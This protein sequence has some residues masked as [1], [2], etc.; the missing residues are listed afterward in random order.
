[1][2]VLE[3]S[4]R[5]DSALTYTKA[6]ILDAAPNRPG[7]L[8]VVVLVTDGKSDE[9]TLYISYL[10]EISWNLF[11]PQSLYRTTFER[12]NSFRILFSLA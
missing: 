5:I 9:G 7:V 4:T 10:F 3:G 1:M 2:D 6:N 8:D 12:S 11:F